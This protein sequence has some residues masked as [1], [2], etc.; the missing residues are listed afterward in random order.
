MT[1]GLLGVTAVTTLAVML[2][3]P[4]D[5]LPDPDPDD[6]TRVEVRAASVEPEVA[7]PSPP[8]PERA[9]GYDA[10]PGAAPTAAP[11]TA[12]ESR[13]ATTVVLLAMDD[14]LDAGLASSVMATE[15]VVAAT[16]TRAAHVGLTG[17]TDAAGA[18]RDVVPDG[19]RIPVTLLAIEPVG[20][21]RHLAGTL[22]RD[23]LMNLGRLAPGR[24]LLSESSARL[25]GLG[26]GARVD[27]AGALDLEVVGVVSDRAAAGHE[28]VAHADDAALVWFGGRATLLIHHLVD[29]GEELDRVIEREGRRVDA[30]AGEE[31]LRIRRRDDGPSVPLV[32]DSVAIKE[33]FGEFAFRL[34][35]GER[36]VV[37][38]PAYVDAWIVTERLP[39]IGAVRCNRLIMDDLRAAVDELIAA[40]H[41]ALL[42]PRRYA[43]CYHP[44]RIGF[45]RD[46]LSRH[47]WGV[48]I[49]LNVDTSLP[50]GG[51]VL[52]DDVIAIM[53]R[54]GFRWGGDFRTPDNHHFEWVGEIAL[55]RPDRHRTT[56]G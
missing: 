32:L 20:W 16:R 51:A 13:P 47:A 46:T 15:G 19:W 41:E 21:A 53:A 39:V 34:V 14:V 42:S 7:A 33:R 40:G 22:E 24:V 1:A 52:P 29:A 26:E 54:H 17:S 30:A 6:A 49:D 48:A 44:R 18:P 50:G 2:A 43:G 11:G 8:P 37:V 56:Q 31:V 28:F 12:P 55:L 25:R 4:L 5:V 3:A 10:R 45:S 35:P 27:L 23:D 9:P 38:D 36:E